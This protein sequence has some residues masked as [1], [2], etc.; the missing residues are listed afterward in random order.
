MERNGRLLWS[1]QK[2]SYNATN[3]GESNKTLLHKNSQYLKSITDEA[4]NGYGTD[5]HS[6]MCGKSWVLRIC[7]NVSPEA[8]TI[9]SSPKHIPGFMEGALFYSQ[10]MGFREISQGCY[11]QACSWV[12]DGAMLFSIHEV[13]MERLAWSGQ[14]STQQCLSFSNGSLSH[15]VELCFSQEENWAFRY[16]RPWWWLLGLCNAPIEQFV[17]MRICLVAG[18]N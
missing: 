9:T 11:W 15:V 1:H 14:P 16:T 5:N 7:S 12:W 2:L 6:P 10:Y 3:S 17:E 4:Y 8:Q 13:L 18:C